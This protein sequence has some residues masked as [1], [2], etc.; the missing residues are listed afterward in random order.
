MNFENTIISM[1][2]WTL[3]KYIIVLCFHR[4]QIHSLILLLLRVVQLVAVRHA[5]EHIIF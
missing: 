4:F 2:L 1:F 3:L 5:F